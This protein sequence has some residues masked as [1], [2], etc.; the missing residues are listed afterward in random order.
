[1]PLVSLPYDAGYPV[2]QCL[3]SIQDISFG[4][5]ALECNCQQSSGYP[6][7]SCT[8]TT[9][10]LRRHTCK[11]RTKPCVLW[12]Q[13]LYATHGKMTF[14]PTAMLTYTQAVHSFTFDVFQAYTLNITI[15]ITPSSHGELTIV[16][17]NTDK[18]KQSQWEITI[19]IIKSK[20]I[21]HKIWLESLAEESG[22]IS[23][24]LPGNVIQTVNKNEWKSSA[25][26]RS[27]VRKCCLH[28]N[29]R[30][31]MQGI[32]ENKRVPAS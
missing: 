11:T 13:G 2:P 25:G 19:Y 3:N 31:W 5:R 10:S 7:L 24:V 30:E 1:M 21:R 23:Y 8:P 12:G 14:K 9:S 28:K 4:S 29:K 18:V 22:R 6:W 32:S 17:W 20:V 16:I 26:W 27:H 15:H